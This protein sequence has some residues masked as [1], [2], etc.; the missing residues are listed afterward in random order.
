MC[1][2]SVDAHVSSGAGLA[3]ILPEFH[4]SPVGIIYFIPVGDSGNRWNFF[5]LFLFI[6]LCPSSIKW[7]YSSTVVG[8]P[9][10]SAV[11]PATNGFRLAAWLGQEI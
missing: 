7:R 3:T 11:W 6:E 2:L 8:R 1:L 9:A 5:I 4:L 10:I